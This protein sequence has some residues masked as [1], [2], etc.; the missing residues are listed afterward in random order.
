[1]AGTPLKDSGEREHFETGAMRE[2]A[3]HAF[4]LIPP[5]MLVRLATHYLNATRKYS[6]RN[7]ENGMPMSRCMSSI[8]SHWC[9]FMAGDRAEDHLCAIIWNAAAVITYEARVAAGKLS[10]DLNDLPP[11]LDSRAGRTGPANGHDGPLTRESPH[12]T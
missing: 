8:M 1:M 12:E 10:P 5:E 7:W 3:Q 2:P 9:Q 6:R 4:D 11:A